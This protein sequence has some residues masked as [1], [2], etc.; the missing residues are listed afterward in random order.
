M[1]L[2]TGTVSFVYRQQQVI[3]SEQAT[4]VSIPTEVE[5]FMAFFILRGPLTHKRMLNRR[6]FVFRHLASEKGEASCIFLMD[7]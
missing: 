4:K 6:L 5:A 7:F 1:P 3:V 2:K